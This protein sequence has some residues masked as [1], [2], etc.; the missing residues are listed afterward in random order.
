MSKKKY[1]KPAPALISCPYPPPTCH[2]SSNIKLAGN[3]CKDEDLLQQCLQQ[4]S[5]NRNQIKR[6][7]KI[8]KLKLKNTQVVC[9]CGVERIVTILPLFQSLLYLL[10]PH[11]SLELLT[12]DCV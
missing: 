11:L 7:D 3:T 4:V 6:A 2:N 8:R 1:I 12:S 10:L 5:I 9:S